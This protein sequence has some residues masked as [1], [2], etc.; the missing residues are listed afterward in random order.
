MNQSSL[1]SGCSSSVDTSVPIPLTRAWCGSE[2]R[3]STTLPQAGLCMK[4]SSTRWWEEAGDLCACSLGQ[5]GPKNAALGWSPVLWRCCPCT[6]EMGAKSS[7][8]KQNK[9]KSSPPRISSGF[10]VVSLPALLLPH[11]C[12]SEISLHVLGVKNMLVKLCTVTTN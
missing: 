2:D 11:P 5:H 4:L 12:P 3:S 1:C 10:V 9:F 8:S 6:R 7:L